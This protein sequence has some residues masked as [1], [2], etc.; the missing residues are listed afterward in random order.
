MGI[1]FV[2]AIFI[3]VAAIIVLVNF[4]SYLAV[5]RIVTKEGLWKTIQVWTVLLVPFMYLIISDLG[6][7][8]SCCGDTAIFSPEYRIGIYFLMFLCI[9]AY[10]VSAW[11]K[12]LLS[13]I[14]ELVINVFLI[15]G[16]IINV[17]LSVH[18]N[19]IDDG[20]LFWIFGNLPIILLILIKLSEN[21]RLIKKQIAENQIEAK[22]EFGK[23]CMELLSLQPILKYSVL[24]MMLIPI[25]VFVSMF[26]MLFG[27][28]PDSLIR[29]FTDTY[30]HGFSQLDHLCANVQCGGHFLC[31]VGANG[32]REVVKPIRYGER[33]GNKIICNRQL[34]VSNAFEEL[35]QERSPILHANLR[36]NYNK[37]GDKI[38]KHYHVFNN[39]YVSDLVYL[40]MKPLEYFFLIVL[41]TFDRKPED[42]IERQY[43]SGKDRKEL[44]AVRDEELIL[45]PLYK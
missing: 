41:Y 28:K 39:K 26:L 24:T 31:S 33:K 21:H 20:Y 42:R 18:L 14:Q 40:F 6:N 32:H 27:Q 44:M 16:L 35:V 30:K 11:R 34:L 15:L 45:K 12:E 36:A 17:L 25:L 10:L 9:G 5:D 3:V 37:V 2:V 8:N 22:G 38:H 13:P 1:L 4:I 29:A 43:L 23:L 7:S 19:D